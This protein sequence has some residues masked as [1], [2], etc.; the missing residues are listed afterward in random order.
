MS[1]AVALALAAEAQA[2]RGQ[3][4]RSPYSLALAYCVLLALPAS[5]VY[6]AVDR[7]QDLPAIG[8]AI[9]TDSAGQPLILAAPDETTR[10][11][12]DM[13]AR[14]D[15]ELIGPPMDERAIVPL[16]EL[17]AARPHAFVV[18]QWPGRET[19]PAVQ[20]LAHALGIKIDPAPADRAEPAWAAAAGLAPVHFYALPNGRRYA[21]LQRAE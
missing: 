7:W 3:M 5:A 12:I 15:V 19:T 6:R 18:A 21:L 4:R 9:G 20:R 2:R 16:R 17:T 1:A 8:R 10:A 11:F 14:T 13:Y